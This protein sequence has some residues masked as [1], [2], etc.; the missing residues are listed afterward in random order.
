MTGSIRL[1]LLFLGFL[2]SNHF[3]NAQNTVILS[4]TATDEITELPIAAATV[5]LTS[6]KD[7]ALI[8]Y[9][10]TDDHGKFKLQIKKIDEPVIF[11]VT[12]DL[13]GDYEKEFESIDKDFDFGSIRL[14][15]KIDLE[16]AVINAAPPIR[17]KN[18][19][20]EFDA[21]SFK[22]RPDANVESLLKQLP[23]VDIDEDGKITVNGKEVNQIL[24]N[25][26]PFFDKDGKIALENLPAEIINKVQVI[27]TKTKK[28]ELSG[29][30]ASSNNAT[31]NLT[32]DKEKNKG[33]MLKAMAGYGT[34]DRYESSLMLNYFKG[35]SRL[36]ILGSSNNINSVGFSMNEIFDNMGSMRRS[37][38]FVNDNGSFGING[39]SFGSGKG[40]T[41]S[42]L[43]GISYSDAFA[44]GLDYNGNYFYT[45]TDTRNNNFSRQQNLLPD[46]IYTTESRSKLRNQSYSNNFSSSFEIKLGKT[47]SIWLE[48]KYSSNK[49]K[50]SN[51]F[52]S[53]TVNEAGD[54]LNES[55][56]ETNSESLSQS[57]ANSFEYFKSFENKTDLSL[58]FSNDN[59]RKH[60]DD[61]NISNTFFYQTDDP[62][63]LRNQLSKTSNK[64]EN[65]SFELEYSFPVADSVKLGIG[66]EYDI[67]RQHDI[68]S[69]LDFDETSGSYSIQNDRLSTDLASDF[70]NLNPYVSL[71]IQ[72]K[73]FYFSLTT[74][75]QLM[76]QKDRGYYMGDL[77]E[78][79]QDDALPSLNLY[80][81]YRFGKNASIYINYNLEEN[82]ANASQLLPIENLSNPLNT[83]IGNPDLK[84]LKGHT[85]YIGF[86][87]FNFQSK[88]GF[89]LYMG[90]RYDER[91]VVNFK[92]IDENF[93][94]ETTYVNISGNYN[95]WM[96]FNINKS[97]KSGN[98]K[99]RAGLGFSGTHSF[100]QGFTN[101]VK[102]DARSYNFRPRVNFNWDLGEVLNVNPS[103]NLNYQ[104]TEY[105]NYRI[106][107][108]DNLSHVFKLSTTNY[109]PKHFVFGND[110]S[111]T[112]N[113]NI[114]NG[115][116]KDFF[117]W[118]TSLGYNFW[119]DQLTFK[120]KVYDV[121]GQNTGVSRTISDTLISDVQ[122]DV[123]TRY[124]MFSLGYKLDKFGGKKKG[125][126][127]RFIMMD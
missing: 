86:N 121:L 124:V 80:S 97:F 90:G 77:Y 54:L 111:Y 66:S 115:F 112:Y 7:S 98:S 127:G 13:F 89:N 16:G 49:I 64:R 48:P 2:I 18:D 31:I 72:K 57:F 113:S 79:K 20:L 42:N 41:A 67:S 36:S 102:Y 120:V 125:G 73:K 118:N 81:N 69:T 122:D 24:V 126:R 46:N 30:K 38:M 105:K 103:Y 12:D 55:N 33:V 5:F 108:S 58:S 82:Y 56:G 106:D 65:Y 29:Q 27:D 28:E 85:V 6:K 88:T 110:F 1:G 91:N 4:G 71:K 53:R 51:V 123:L 21:A 40:I 75:V 99:F 68:V 47:S 87:N 14:S 8:D 11:R 25:G 63:D 119:K 84:T 3:L 37:S 45:Q 44:K 39:M 59:S 35:D 100:R 95:L 17:I 22:V 74:G 117:L 61:Y 52:D 107:K 109:W 50:S 26:K 70:N 43:G 116:K 78:L 94:S 83:I 19:T 32:I 23:G 9:T 34:D 76:N 60:S 96:G 101:G 15:Q 10:L 92:T 62:D 114:S 93:K 104:F